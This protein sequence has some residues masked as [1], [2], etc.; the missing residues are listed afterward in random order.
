[1]FDTLF[2][3]AVNCFKHISFSSIVFENVMSN[4]LCSYQQKKKKHNVT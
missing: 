4:I 1:M 3:Y 2:I